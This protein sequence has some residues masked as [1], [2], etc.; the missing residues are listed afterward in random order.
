M[1]AFVTWKRDAD[2][3]ASGDW[4]GKKRPRAAEC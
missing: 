1:R 4:R 3:Y 2:Y